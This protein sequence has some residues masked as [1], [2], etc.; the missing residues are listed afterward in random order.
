MQRDVFLILISGAISLASAVVTTLLQDYLQTRKQRRQWGREDALRRE[1]ELRGD[2]SEI[3]ALER[4]LESH[5]LE[6]TKKLG[7]FLAE[8]GGE[9]PVASRAVAWGPLIVAVVLCVAILAVVIHFGLL[10][11]LR[12][13]ATLPVWM[14]ALGAVILIN[15]VDIVFLRLWVRHRKGQR[16]VARLIELYPGIDEC[17]YTPHGRPVRRNQ[18]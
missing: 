11:L 3:H 6:E 7:Y 14:L 8:G 17:L 13:L 9:W 15:V 12:F 10:P 2:P 4:R 18:R 5:A 16:I 1:A